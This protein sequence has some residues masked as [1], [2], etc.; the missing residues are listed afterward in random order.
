MDGGIWKSLWQIKAPKKALIFVW[1]ALTKCLPI[2]T[3]LH[4][5]RVQIDNLCDVCRQGV[6]TTTHI[7]LQCPFA[8]SCWMIYHSTP[9]NSV[10]WEFSEWFERC[11]LSHSMDGKANMVMLCWAIWR[12]R[13]DAVWNQKFSTPTRVVANTKEYLSQWKKTQSLFYK[14]PLQPSLQGDGAETWVK[15]QQNIVKIIVDAAI[16]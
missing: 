1:R 7:L 9:V 4:Q 11:L 15:P 8:A 6:E 3:Q 5:K 10:R 12:S 16:F 14:V 13:N 2:K